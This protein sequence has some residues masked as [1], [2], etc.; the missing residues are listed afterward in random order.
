[1]A[2]EKVDAYAKILLQIQEKTQS[3]H[4]G[5]LR[6]A[7]LLKYVGTITTH[8]NGESNMHSMSNEL[9]SDG[10]MQCLLG[11]RSCDP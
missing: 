1:M 5:M 3:W 2:V 8:N 7:L 11:S 9:L 4:I 6:V 10:F